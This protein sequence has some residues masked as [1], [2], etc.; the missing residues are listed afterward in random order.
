MKDYEAYVNNG[1]LEVPEYS[2]ELK[3]EYFDLRDNKLPGESMDSFENS[4]ACG[5]GG[6]TKSF[7]SNSSQGKTL[8]DVQELTNA[9][10]PSSTGS[11]IETAGAAVTGTATAVVGAAVAV[12]A[13]NAAPKA[14]PKMKINT[15]ESGSSYV[16]YNLEAMNLDLDKDYDIIISNSS[17]K[18]K[19]D[20]RPGVNDEYVYDL[21]SG[22]QYTLTLVGY[23]ELLGTV[24]YQTESFFTLNSKS[25]VGYSNIDVVYNDD[26]TCGI[27]Y[28]T[29]VIDDYN[30]LNGTYIVIKLMMEEFQGE[31]MVI[32]HS[33]YTEEMDPNEFTYKY[34]NKVHSGTLNKVDPGTIIIELYRDNGDEYEGIL[35]SSYE[36][37]IKYPVF[38]RTD[39]NYVELVGDYNLIK[40]VKNINS[41][42]DNLSVIFTLYNDDDDKTNIERQINVLNGDFTFKQLVKQDTSAYSYKLGYY[43]ADNE[44]V[45]VKEKPKEEFY[46]GYYSA[47]YN[48]V[49]NKYS[50]DYDGYTN[51]LMD[52]KWNYDSDNNETMDITVLTDFD[53]YGNNDVYYKVDLLR[54]IMNHDGEYEVVDTYIGTSNAVFKNVPTFVYNEEYENMWVAHY[55]LEYTSLVNYYDETKGKVQVA[56]ETHAEDV[57]FSFPTAVWVDNE[58]LTYRGDGAFALALDM[59]FEGEERGFVGDFADSKATLYFHNGNLPETTGS[60]D[61]EGDIVEW[62]GS[63][64]YIIF[65]KPLPTDIYG[66]LITYEINYHDKCG[67]NIRKSISTERI[68]LGD[69]G[70]QVEASLEKFTAYGDYYS[71]EIHLSA[72]MPEDGTLRVK[73]DEGD[74]EI[75]P[76]INGKYVYTFEEV[77]ASS[78]IVVNVFDSNGTISTTDAYTCSYRDAVDY[79]FGDISYYRE[80]PNYHVT[81]TYNDDGTVNIYWDTGFAD[82]AEGRYVDPVSFTMNCYLQVFDYEIGDYK[83]V[84]SVMGIKNGNTIAVFKNVEYAGAA[85]DYQF[86]YEYIYSSREEYITKDKIITYP[87]E[88]FIMTESNINSMHPNGQLM[89]YTGYDEETGK[90]YVSLNIPVDMIY[91]KDQTVTFEKYTDPEH[92]IEKTFK[93]SDCL[94][95]STSDGD[96]YVFNFDS[97]FEVDGTTSLY[98]MYN[99][100][101]TNSNYNA[102][103]S[104]YSGNLYNKYSVFVT[105]V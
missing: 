57:N 30:T 46:G 87:L 10:T 39:S 91:D 97:D 1:N 34:E 6:K 94:V 20:C 99:Y 56:M 105:G 54:E 98:V 68:S 49:F 25:I 19:L 77:S 17:Q 22:L 85:T 8:D 7:S 83:D 59:E 42:R 100:T 89:G 92:T 40:D 27:S 43:T 90:Y 38:E 84:G 103:S 26:L 18:I 53:N 79:D 82:L 86:R 23:S 31:E 70:Y 45:V 13:F 66:C 65:D 88:T 58:Q 75:V 96:Y 28:K 93:L 32:F 72:Y 71:G 4:L 47:Y 24:E 78:R 64:P 80:D 81:F 16:H 14:L 74:Y 21:K 50:V 67:N 9:M 29:T 33:K 69:L 44:F 95:S 3:I 51:Y 60:L 73:I 76:L 63:Y 101:L 12:V 11:I 36:K 52:I 41:N 35:I 62:V 55:K 5:I 48:P 2:K 102:I 104:I 61:F 37:E 15:L